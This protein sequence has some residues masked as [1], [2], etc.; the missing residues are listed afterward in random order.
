MK[1]YY[2]MGS[3]N[4]V[5]HILRVPIIQEDQV[6][7]ER[8]FSDITFIDALFTLDLTKN[9]ILSLLQEYNPS[10]FKNI[11]EN[12]MDIFIARV[13]FNEK[14]KTYAVRFYDLLYRYSSLRVAPKIEEG[15]KK[16]AFE[17]IESVQNQQ[18][19]LLQLDN[20]FKDFLNLL[21]FYTTGSP[22]TKSFLLRS[23]SIVDPEIKKNI[24]GYY[25][26]TDYLVYHKL[27]TDLRSYKNLR[28]FC[29]ELLQSNSLNPVN[30]KEK[31]FER[32]HYIYPS[33]LFG[34]PYDF[35]LSLDEINYIPRDYVPPVSYEDEMVAFEAKILRYIL[36]QPF[37]NTEMQDYYEQGG[38]EAIFANM[39]A[40][41]IYGSLTDE[42]KVKLNLLSIHKYVEMNWSK[43]FQYLQNDHKNQRRSR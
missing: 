13:S 2:V 40:N 17:R 16:E 30:F 21:L 9:E 38:L 5:A 42:D 29:L 14:K 27:E 23:E 8:E 41:D 1:K 24:R 4:K 26:S 12:D 15:I 22:D 43:I 35:T 28:G 19:I 33:E 11:N 39:D 18:R 34:Y 3:K 20:K 32:K 31:N 36:Q 37:S 7:V 6:A 10:F 25:R